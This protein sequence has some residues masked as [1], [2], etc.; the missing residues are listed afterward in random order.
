V[1]QWITFLAWLV[2]A[3]TLIFIFLWPGVEWLRSLPLRRSAWTKR[4]KL[5]K[6]KKALGTAKKFVQSDG[7]VADLERVLAREEALVNSLPRLFEPI[8][9]DYGWPNALDG[10]IV[11]TGVAAASFFQNLSP[12]ASALWK[13][14]GTFL[15]FLGTGAETWWILKQ[16]APQFRLHMRVLSCT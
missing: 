1:Q 15:L 16:R 12:E 11:I 14:W 13:F 7:A 5:K 4:R 10:L 8:A 6:V 3:D 2:I 9:K